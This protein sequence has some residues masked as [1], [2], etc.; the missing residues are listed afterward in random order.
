MGWG[1]ESIGTLEKYLN[2]SLI[3]KYAMQYGTSVLGAVAIF[4][5]GRLAAKWVSRSVK[6]IL[7]KSR[8]DETLVSFFGNVLFFV[9][10]ALVVIAALGQLGVQTTTAAA[11]FAAAGLAVGLALQNSL[12]NFASGVLIIM[13]RPF[14][15]GDY[16]TAGGQS[17]TV[18]E[19][20]I[21]TTHMRTPD[22]IEVIVP[23]S[24]ITSGNILNFNSNKKRRIDLV[25][26]IGYRDDIVRAKAVLLDI[27][28]KDP[29]ILHDPPPVIAVLALGEYAVQLAVRP[30]VLTK[31]Y[32]EVYFDLNESVKLRFDAEGITFPT[33]PS[34]QG[35]GGRRVKPGG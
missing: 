30:W 18:E 28:H 22:N 23:N 12:S 6:R 14:R 16:I 1:M 33:V 25:Y 32:W 20:N 2:P 21:F 10:L 13:F 3:G 35:E 7:R 24:A 29:R 26:G 15:V 8:L 27:L 34:L 31:E 17:G 11:V 4:L 9:L 19:V 5:L